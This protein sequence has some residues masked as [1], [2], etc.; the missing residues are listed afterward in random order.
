MWQVQ[1][2]ACVGS[3]VKGLQQAACTGPVF[4]CTFISCAF[5][6]G[7]GSC[8]LQFLRSKGRSMTCSTTELFVPCTL[9]DH[10]HKHLSRSLKNSKVW[11]PLCCHTPCRKVVIM[12]TAGSAPCVTLLRPMVPGMHH[13]TCALLLHEVG[14]PKAGQGVQASTHKLRTILMLSLQL[15]SLAATRPHTDTTGGRTA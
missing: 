6:A 13:H 12:P 9:V 8:K 5:R 4:T 10:R 3:C 2:H 15:R 11:S 1:R 14:Q 7:A